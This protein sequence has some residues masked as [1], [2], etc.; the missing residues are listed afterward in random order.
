MPISDAVYR[1]LYEK[2]SPVIEIRLLCDKLT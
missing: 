1:V 2:M